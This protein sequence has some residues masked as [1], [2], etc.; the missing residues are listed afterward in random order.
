MVREMLQF[1][2]YRIQWS[3]FKKKYTCTEHCM[4]S[5]MIFVLDS[6]LL[7]AILSV[8]HCTLGMKLQA[9]RAEYRYHKMTF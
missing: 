4:V 1:V 8:V 5:V 9:A 7:C 3:E 2:D 6:A